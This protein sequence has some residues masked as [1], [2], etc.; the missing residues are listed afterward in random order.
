MRTMVIKKAAQKILPPGLFEILLKNY[1]RFR[2]SSFDLDRSI[3]CPMI[4]QAGK[5]ESFLEKIKRTGELNGAFKAHRDLT[6]VT[7]HN[8]AE[9]SL[10]EQSLS[11]VG[12]RE[13][14]EVLQPAAGVTW[15]NT[16]KIELILKYLN[17]GRCK[18]K[19]VMYCDA[20]DVVLRGGPEKILEVFRGYECDLLFMSTHFLGGYMC[21]PEVKEWADNIYPGRYLN[22]GIFIGQ[23]DF[24]WEVMTDATKYLVDNPITKQEYIDLGS[25]ERDTR[26]CARLPDYPRGLSQDQHI[27]RYLHPKYFPRMKIDY[28]NRLAWRNSKHV[29]D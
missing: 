12:L 27:L 9:P 3:G 26:L 4:H 7:A 23:P 17:S 2:P 28:T 16:L 14:C 29:C 13:C 20:R 11:Y 8:Y 6:F 24:I 1:R 18:T 10:F 19:F 22:S 15:R 25:G 21:M 5:A